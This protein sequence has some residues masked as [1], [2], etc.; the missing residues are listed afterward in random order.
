MISSRRLSPICFILVERMNEHHI[1]ASF[2]STP[3]VFAM[4]LTVLEAIVVLLL[5]PETS[6]AAKTARK[7]SQEK[8]NHSTISLSQISN[9]LNPVALFQFRAAVNVSNTNHNSANV[10]SLAQIGRIYTMYLLLYSGLE[11]TL[12]FLT[13][14]L[15]RFDYDSM[16][17][18]RM[19][20]FAGLI[21][22]AV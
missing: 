17:Q 21:M 4:I 22:I 9:L 16:K 11:F 15:L 14:F 18:G 12:S 13:R 5:L 1:E 10:S 6:N 7:S 3:A 2:C 20:V 19:Y 8:Q